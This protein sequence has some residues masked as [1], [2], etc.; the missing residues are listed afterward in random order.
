MHHSVPATWIFVTE[1]LGAQCPEMMSRKKPGKARQTFASFS[2]H[3][4]QN[5]TKI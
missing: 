1:K 2:S 4:Y 3:F 5:L